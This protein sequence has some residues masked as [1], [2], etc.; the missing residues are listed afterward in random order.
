MKN[1]IKHKFA[2]RGI[3]NWMTNMINFH[4]CTINTKNLFLPFVL[5]MEGEFVRFLIRWPVA[6]VSKYQLGSM[7]YKDETAL[8]DIPPLSKDG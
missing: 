4:T 7:A 3:N 6:S 5:L 1:I 8:C 2:V